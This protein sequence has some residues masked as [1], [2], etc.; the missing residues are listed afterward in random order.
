MLTHEAG[1]LLKEIVEIDHITL[2]QAIQTNQHNINVVPDSVN[3]GGPPYNMTKDRTCSPQMREQALLPHN[4]SN[5]L[6]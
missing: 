1:A 4:Q 2:S 5:L 3:S 6:N